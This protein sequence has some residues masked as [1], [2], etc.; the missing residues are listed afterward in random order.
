MRKSDIVKKL[1]VTL[2]LLP[3]I[4]IAVA[5][6]MLT[7]QD[8]RD[9]ALANNKASLI[10]REKVNAAVYDKKAAR[11]NYFPKVSVTGAYLHNSDGISL[12]DESSVASLSGIGTSVGNTLTGY[13][14]QMMT[15]PKFLQTLSA[16]AGLQYLVGKLGALDIAEPLNAI[17][18]RVADKFSFDATN[19]YVGVVTVEEPVY[20]GGKIRAYNKVTAYAEELAATQ[21][22]GEDR[23]VL[24]TTDEAY[25]QI[26]SIAGKLELARKYVE[27]LERLDSD[28][29]KMRNEGVATMSD[30]LA[31]KVRLNEAEMTRL[32]AQNGLALS[33][34]LLCQLC[35]LDIHSDIVL[36]DEDNLEIPVPVTR[37]EYTSLDIE[38][39]RPELRS[40]RLATRMY[41]QKT[42]IVQSDYLPTLAVMGNY[43]LTNPNLKH[44]FKNEFS[45]L[46]SV[47]VVARI[48]VFHFG[49][50]VNKIRHAKSDA[51]IAQYQLDEARG[52][53]SLQ[54][55]Q[56]EQKIAEADSRLE[57]SLRNMDN[58]EE[59]LRMAEIGFREGMLEPNVVMQAQTAWMQARSEEIDARIDRIMADVYLRQATGMW[60]N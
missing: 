25:W 11:A 7:L 60:N 37:P 27:L 26:V 24:V 23:K 40:L 51:L 34:M 9:L 53:I 8:C 36:A 55:T 6:Q 3:A 28:V 15:D 49:E 33:K 5:Q 50:G 30:Q 22:E 14:M 20:A 39:N 10:A 52:K 12:L 2:A 32:R 35:G 59:N 54:V 18:S 46:W 56:Y 19:I 29:E 42:R 13:V 41:D 4:T 57:M 43:L 48:P 16:D 31:V 1:V 58:A 38:E 47:G 44:G 21:L 45:G 17:G